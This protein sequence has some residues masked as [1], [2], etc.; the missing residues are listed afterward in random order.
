MPET[1]FLWQPFKE[2]AICQHEFQNIEYMPISLGCGHTVCHGCLS[3]ISIT[4]CPID[5][6]SKIH[7]L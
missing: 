3:E 7:H 2:C 5:Y 6:V 4:V 1:G